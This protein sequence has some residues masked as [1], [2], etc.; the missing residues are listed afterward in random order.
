STSLR[1]L[2]SQHLLQ[3]ADGSGRFAALEILVNTPATANLV[4]QGKLDQ[5]ENTMLGAAA[6]GMRTM[7][8]SIQ[9]LLDH[10]LISGSEAFKKAI[11]KS[12]FEAVRDQD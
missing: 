2:V 1:G 5:L 12:R 11:N 10:R 8:S 9:S 6:L 4:R 7:D 3:L